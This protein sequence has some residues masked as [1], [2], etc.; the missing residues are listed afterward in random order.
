MLV[1]WNKR[2]YKF[3]LKNATLKA[4]LYELTDELNDRI[5]QLIKWE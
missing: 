3:M 4:K 5:I 1:I 2:G